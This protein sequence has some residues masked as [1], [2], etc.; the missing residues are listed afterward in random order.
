[1][2]SLPRKFVAIVLPGQA[3]LVQQLSLY[4]TGAQ[5]YAGHFFSVFCRLAGTAFLQSHNQGSL[6]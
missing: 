6:E 4:L 1:M 5:E 2:C 3:G